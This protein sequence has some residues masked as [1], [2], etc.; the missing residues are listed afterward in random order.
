MAAVLVVSIVARMPGLFLGE[1]W[2][3]PDVDG[4]HDHPAQFHD[5]PLRSYATFTRNG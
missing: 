3:H 1:R 4:I 5:C 2:R